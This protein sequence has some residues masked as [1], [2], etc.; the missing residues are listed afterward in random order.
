MHVHVHVKRRTRGGEGKKSGQVYVRGIGTCT[1][2]SFERKIPTVAINSAI[3]V[4]HIVG[5]RH[6]HVRVWSRGT[7]A[8]RRQWYNIFPTGVGRNSPDAGALDKPEN[9]A[10]PMTRSRRPIWSLKVVS[11]PSRAHIRPFSSSM[12]SLCAL[13]SADSQLLP[14]LLPPLLLLLEFF[15][16]I[17]LISSGLSL[18]K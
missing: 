15:R 11:M 6:A 2:L 13:L 17:R 3:C 8:E 1:C 16:W 14:L 12:D 10:G 5:F 18:R 4:L 9:V 7:Q